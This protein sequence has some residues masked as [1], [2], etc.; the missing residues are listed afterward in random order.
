MLEAFVHRVRA[1]A[2]VQNA[3]EGGMRSECVKTKTI[4]NP[5]DKLTHHKFQRWGYKLKVKDSFSRCRFPKERTHWKL[6][7]TFYWSFT[8]EEVCGRMYVQPN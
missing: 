4:K 3:E 8:V 7:G 2:D 1:F 6:C 5:F